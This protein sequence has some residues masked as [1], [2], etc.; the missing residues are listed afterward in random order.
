MTHLDQNRYS[1]QN[2]G[3]WKSLLVHE[4][5]AVR[6][7]REDWRFCLRCYSPWG[8]GSPTGRSCCYNGAVWGE[9]P[10]PAFQLHK[11]LTRPLLPWEGSGAGTKGHF[12]SPGETDYADLI[13]SV[14]GK[15][16]PSH[17][18]LCISLAVKRKKMWP[19]VRRD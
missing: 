8:P 7:E 1:N 13:N 3:G 17:A 12:G 5:A 9:R 4:V 2:G 11:L 10:G 15:Q 6:T 18:F 16:G 14:T 19:Q